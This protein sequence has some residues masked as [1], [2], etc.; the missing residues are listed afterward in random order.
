MVNF[1]MT[2]LARL[3]G[4]ESEVAAYRGPFVGWRFLGTLL[5]AMPPQSADIQAAVDPLIAGL[6]LLAGGQNWPEAETAAGTAER[7]TWGLR[8]PWAAKIR[9]AAHAAEAAA[10]TGTV[11][12]TP[13]ILWPNCRE[14]A[15]AVAYWAA[16][17]GVPIARQRE[18]LLQLM[19]D[20]K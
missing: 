7:A 10:Q 1:D 2:P 18:I 20:A 14:C 16:K 8:E 3:L 9:A 11:V 12:L 13:L 6:D 5:R 19:E 15:H 4:C 17:A